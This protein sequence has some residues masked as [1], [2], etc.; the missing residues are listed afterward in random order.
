MAAVFLGPAGREEYYDWAVVRYWQIFYQFWCQSD[1][2]GNL[3]N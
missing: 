2:A 1:A 3:P